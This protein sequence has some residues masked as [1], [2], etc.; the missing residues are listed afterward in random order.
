MT[1]D[2]IKYTLTLK[3]KNS[4]EQ[5]TYSLDLTSHQEDYPEQIFTL[6]MREDI[7]NYLQEKSSCKISDSHLNFMV[8]TW[9]EDIK[10]GYRNSNIDIDLPPMTID[11]IEGLTE[12]GNQE[13]PKPIPPDLS[14]IEPTFGMLPPLVFS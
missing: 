7:R 4:H 6:K 14:N 8:K 9:I 5:Y 13:I 1:N 2:M 11:D 3:L 10:E 12:T